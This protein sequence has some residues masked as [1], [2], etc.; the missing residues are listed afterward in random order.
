MHRFLSFP[1]SRVAILAALGLT[2][3]ACGS[4]D[5]PPGGGEPGDVDALL[6]ALPPW[7]AFSP[8]LDDTPPTP[9]E[10][11][12]VRVTEREE[13]LTAITDEDR[14]GDGV[15]DI[16]VVEDVVSRCTSVPYTMTDT[17]ER[18][19]MYS[20]DVELLWPGALLQ[21]RSHRDGLG[22]LSAL[23]I[24]E[25]APLE[26]SIPAFSTGDNFRT[27]ERP[28][29]AQV[30]SAIGSIV[31]DAVASDLVTPSTITFE[32]NTYHSE[33]EFALS[34]DMSGRYLGFEAS[35]S[36]DVEQSASRTT[37]TAQF[38]QKMFEVVVAPPST[39][40]GFF[41]DEFTPAA[42][43]AQEALGRI[44]P[45]N[46]PIYVSNV[47]YGRMMTF[48][49]TSTASE[50]EIR[51]TL[52]AAYD[53]LVGGVEANLDARQR[54]ILAESTIA[55]SSLGG[56][57]EA[58]IAMIRSG[59]WQDYFAAEA[60]LSSAAPL[61][62]T[63]RNLGD[64]TIASVSEA[65]EYEITTCVSRAAGEVFDFVEELAFDTV[66][67]APF[68]AHA[69]D[70]DGD[71][72]DDV[73]WNHRSPGANA[74]VVGYGGPDG[75]LTIGEPFTHPDPDALGGWG[76]YRVRVGDVDGDGQDD[77]V[78]NRLAPENTWS[79]ARFDGRDAVI[80]DAVQRHP[81]N[82]WSRYVANLGDV[83]GDGRDDLHWTQT[84]RSTL[85]VYGG[86]RYAAETGFDLLPAHDL[87]STLR[88]LAWT[89][90]L[91]V[92]L[93]DLDAD[94]DDDL[95]FVLRHRLLG[96]LD[97]TIA[98]WAASDGSAQMHPRISG[99]YA[100]PL[101]G[102]HRRSPLLVDSFT[103]GDAD[104]VLIL[105]WGSD[106]TDPYAVL[107]DFPGRELTTASGPDLPDFRAFDVLDGDVDGD[108]RQDLIWNLRDG[109]TNE[110]LVGFGR[111]D[112]LDLDGAPQLHPWPVRDWDAYD[113]P[114]VVLDVNGDGRDDLVWSRSGPTV[115]VHVALASADL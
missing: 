30:A 49:L 51:A 46:L 12:E 31:G 104:D 52:S 13:T 79:V 65:T 33:A 11:A 14:D 39:P 63:F 3:T 43:R 73:L 57:A 72:H 2:A 74:L 36:G 8:P 41:S 80:F 111:R 38:T 18:I 24:A 44:G 90:D 34:L 21:G 75:T 81:A 6:R 70:F 93:G 37:V 55:I 78:W 28:T 50:S 91:Q 15:A 26:V 1:V 64:N 96:F 5:D 42:Y 113:L 105:P 103:G 4:P 9:V 108:G 54:A 101:P 7:S 10:G 19:V 67:P 85:R 56:N 66:I 61:S 98:Y 97:Q 115:R 23:P 62:Y 110:M 84:G 109:A 45:D 29:Q 82:G 59:N 102:I 58:T 60:P 112:G 27:V 100:L 92:A 20:P 99:S 95:V 114:P 35:A 17:P 53:G 16:E 77:V 69:G 87:S 40:A 88:D 47:V 89:D 22:S 83:D 86:V 48:S 106:V 68:D 32:E 107:L 94:G 76:N 25:R 71:G